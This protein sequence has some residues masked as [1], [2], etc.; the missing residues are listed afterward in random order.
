Q[1]VARR[2]FLKL[3]E[4]GE[5]AQDTR[6]RASLDELYPRAELRP[7]VEQVLN[8]LVDTRLIVTTDTTA[9]V[10]HEALIREWPP[11][12]TWID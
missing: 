6:R 2:I 9:E 8:K 4:L 3:V 11:F 10:A 12:R 7:A 1:A 5:G